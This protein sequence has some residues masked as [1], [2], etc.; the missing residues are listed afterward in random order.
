MNEDNEVTWCGGLHEEDS[1]S[2]YAASART[3]AKLAAVLESCR[4][5]NYSFADLEEQHHAKWLE[6]E[7]Y[8]AREAKADAE[9]RVVAETSREIF[10]R[11]SQAKHTKTVK[12]AKSAAKKSVK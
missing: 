5:R 12:A 11:M 6:E 3:E 9:A 7:A 2:V 10:R 1:E 8:Y 4:P